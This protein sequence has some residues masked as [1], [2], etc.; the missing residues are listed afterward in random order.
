MIIDKKHDLIEHYYGAK[1]IRPFPLIRDALEFEDLYPNLGG[2]TR[3]LYVLAAPIRDER[4]EIV[5]VMETIQDTSSLI[6][7]ELY[8]FHILN[9]MP[10][11]LA[12]ADDSGKVTLW[13]EA[14]ARA[15]GISRQEAVG[16]DLCELL[17]PFRIDGLRNR[18]RLALT[19]KNQNMGRLPIES[20]NGEQCYWEVILYSLEEGPVKGVIFRAD[21]V[22]R[23]VKL[24]EMMIQTEK[25]VSLGTLAAG[26]AH[27]INNPLAGI[28]Q[29]AQ[30]ARRRLD[31]GLHSTR[32]LMT[33]FFRSPVNWTGWTNICSARK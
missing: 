30:M 19:G 27:E 29:G 2:K 32:R 6:R 1:R 11:A 4:G 25:M 28:L 31:S 13:N 16:K 5:A 9:A 26:V 8:L 22:T 23:R 17:A 20:A 10:S 7:L 33:E 12:A 24:E 18:F 21:D 15:A 3:Q 14:M